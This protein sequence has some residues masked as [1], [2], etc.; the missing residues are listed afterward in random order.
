MNSVRPMGKLFCDKCKSMATI[1]Y[2]YKKNREGADVRIWYRC[3]SHVLDKYEDMV[4]FIDFF[5][6]ENGFSDLV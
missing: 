4:D 2:I 6:E 3:F 5:I 1:K